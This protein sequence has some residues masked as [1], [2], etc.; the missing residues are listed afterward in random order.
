MGAERRHPLRFVW[1]LDEEGCFKL[2]SDEFIEL[3]G[4]RTASMMGKPW[5]EMATEL[6]LDP[7]G[8]IA[9][10]IGTRDTWSGLTV[11][12][13]AGDRNERVAVELSGLPIFDR[14]RI[15]RGYRG[16]G[17]CRHVTRSRPAPGKADAV[18]PAAP[19]ATLSSASVKPAE[20]RPLL[21]V[22][23]AAKNVVPFR[24]GSPAAD[25]RPALTP[26]ERTA[27]Q[28]IGNVLGPHPSDEPTAT[29]PEPIT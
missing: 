27:F 20:P 2:G 29:P 6:A 23:P 22:V 16:F 18:E 3:M 19:D 12:W 24:T 7:A 4:V 8:Q 14:N 5:A 21:S 13:P 9:R 25:R 10:A 26:V 11:S 1:Q 15:F 28:E 17:V